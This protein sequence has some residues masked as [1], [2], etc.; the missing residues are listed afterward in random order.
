MTKND[1]KP[2]NPLLNPTA[3]ARSYN[4]HVP[5]HA[6]ISLS[7]KIALSAFSSCLR[8]VIS[9]HLQKKE[10]TNNI[11]R[12]AFASFLISHGRRFAGMTTRCRLCLF[13]RL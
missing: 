8:D 12:L 4:G 6:H 3:P 10:I 7:L 13:K 2:R 1:F 5:N 9:T 11:H